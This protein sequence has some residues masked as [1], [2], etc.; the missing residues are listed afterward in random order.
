M[1]WWWK[2]FQEP[3]RRQ[4]GTLI[5]ARWTKRRASL[6]M[7]QASSAWVRFYHQKRGKTASREPKQAASKTGR[8]DPELPSKN[9]EWSRSLDFPPVRIRDKR[10][11][12]GRPPGSQSIFGLES[13]LGRRHHWESCVTGWRWTRCLDCIDS[14]RGRGSRRRGSRRKPGSNGAQYGSH[15][16][17]S[18]KVSRKRKSKKD[19]VWSVSSFMQ[20]FRTWQDITPFL[21]GDEKCVPFWYDI[22]FYGNPITL[23]NVYCRDQGMLDCIYIWDN[24]M[25]V[26][27]YETIGGDQC[28]CS[29]MIEVCSAIVL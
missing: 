1:P 28:V 2:S 15:W 21:S 16:S 25:N 8:E 13:K 23:G 17:L 14:K 19:G 20:T 9:L 4:W 7:G 12:L 11:R 6:L 10:P 5:L 26:V 29:F 27:G 22:P 3:G 24:I 18:L